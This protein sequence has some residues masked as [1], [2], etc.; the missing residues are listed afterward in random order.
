MLNIFLIMLG[1]LIALGGLLYLGKALIEEWRDFK[2]EHAP[3]TQQFSQPEIILTEAEKS[4]GWEI[5]EQN[6]VKFKV[7]PRDAAVRAL[8][9]K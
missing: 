5:R 9:G 3:C 8:I 6:G 7:L 4:K 1:A 2:E